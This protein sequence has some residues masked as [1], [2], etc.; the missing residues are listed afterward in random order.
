MQA[1]DSTSEIEAKDLSEFNTIEEL[2]QQ[3]PEKFK[4][5]QLQWSLRFRETNG[6]DA[7]V[8]RFWRRLYIHRP[9]FVKWFAN[10]RS[11]A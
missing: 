5:S 2:C 11:A 7:A 4:K 8:V 6:L 10:Q 1:T 3:Y 9:T